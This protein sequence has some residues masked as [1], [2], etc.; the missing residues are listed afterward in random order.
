MGRTNGGDPGRNSDGTFAKGHSGNKG[1][2]PREVAEVRELAREHT[3]AALKTL[4]TIMEDDDAPHAARVSAANAVLD[5]AVG[6][7]TATLDTTIEDRR[8]HERPRGSTADELLARWRAREAKQAPE[9]GA[10]HDDG[11]A[12]QVGEPNGG[13]SEI[14]YD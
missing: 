1:G 2:R 5:R 10:G 7:P 13:E 8:P 3:E 9:G 14:F 6:K 11:A 12:G 4:A